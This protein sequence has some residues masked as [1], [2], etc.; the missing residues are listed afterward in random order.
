MGAKFY[1]TWC[2]TNQL[3]PLVV[4][5][6]R[7]LAGSTCKRCREK[8]LQLRIVLDGLSLK[9]FSWTQTCYEERNKKACDS[10][11]HGDLMWFGPFCIGEH[12]FKLKFAFGAFTVILL[13][14]DSFHFCWRTVSSHRRQAVMSTTDCPA[15]SNS[16]RQSRSQCQFISR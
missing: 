10:W 9:S 8:Q 14:E 4:A 11:N 13:M 7:K 15:Q 1:I 12:Q 16:Q 3:H 2:S 5:W 6:C